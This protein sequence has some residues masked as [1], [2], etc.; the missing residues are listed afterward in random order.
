MITNVGSIDRIVRVII[1]VALLWFAIFGPVT[2]YN[3]I[4]WIG[5]VPLATALFGV[6]P[7]YSLVGISTCPAKRA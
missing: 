4:G 2:G 7:L 5:I 3:W 1:G 6:C